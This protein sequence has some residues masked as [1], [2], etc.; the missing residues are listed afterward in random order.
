MTE[1]A[2]VTRYAVHLAGE[3]M[4][5]PEGQPV[6]RGYNDMVYTRDYLALKQA[7]AKLQAYNARLLEISVACAVHCPMEGDDMTVADSVGRMK[8]ERDALRA[9]NA[10][11]VRTTK[12]AIMFSEF[13]ELLIM[14]DKLHPGTALLEEVKALKEQVAQFSKA[15]NPSGEPSSFENDL[16]HLEQCVLP[17]WN[18]MKQTL[19]AL[20]GALEPQAM[21]KWFIRIYERV[22]T[23]TDLS[24]ESVTVLIKHDE[25]TKALLTSPAISA[26]RTPTDPS[27]ASSPNESSGQ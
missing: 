3:I 25:Q 21:T 4:E 12:D 26:F 7:H 23:E 18:G 6:S 27:P 16:Y 14:L 1:P 13:H 8:A 15:M 19:T 5:V 2:K 24:V 20:V 9:D 11:L 17:Q 10:A 22:I